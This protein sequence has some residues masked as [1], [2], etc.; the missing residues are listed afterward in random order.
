MAVNQMSETRIDVL[1]RTNQAAPEVLLIAE[2]LANE[3]QRIRGER[4]QPER[5]RDEITKVRASSAAAMAEA[6]A[7]LIARAEKERDTEL[8]ALEKALHDSTAVPLRQLAEDSDSYSRR[9]VSV[10]VTALDQLR[11]VQLAALDAAAVA[12]MTDADDLL[13]LA[14]Q[15][16]AANQ[17]DVTGRMGKV[18][19]ARLQRLVRIESRKGGM[20]G[21]TGPAFLALVLVQDKF[22][23][24]RGAEAAKSP[25]VRRQSVVERHK[26]RVGEIRRGV[27]LAAGDALA[28]QMLHAANR[29]AFGEPPK[30]TMVMGP[31]FEKFKSQVR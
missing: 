21:P 31:A 6:E 5:E 16:L 8:A 14:D 27:K 7:K 19:E 11:R 26:S 4:F 30:P 29:A 15:Y 1:R 10:Q 13:T 17:P 2:T 3:E 18:I 12:E 20:T 9:L 23:H 22:K 25:E 24:W 28:A